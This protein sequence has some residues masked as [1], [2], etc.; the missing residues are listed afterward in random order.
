MMVRA[1]IGY[2]PL[3]SAVECAMPRGH[4]GY[5]GFSHLC[6]HSAATHPRLLEEPVEERLLDFIEVIGV[7]ALI[8]IALLIVRGV[9]V[10]MDA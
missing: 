3:R 2:K 9:T 4:G 7:A 5:W 10:R 1:A 6:A 8:V